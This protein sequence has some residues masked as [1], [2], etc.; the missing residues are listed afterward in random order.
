MLRLAFYLI[1]SLRV[2][3]TKGTYVIYYTETFES[4]TWYRNSGC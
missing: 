1:A 2:T 4:S 3:N